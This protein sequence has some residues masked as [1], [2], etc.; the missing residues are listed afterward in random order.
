MD[1]FFKRPVGIY[2][3]KKKILATANNPYITVI[4]WIDSNDQWDSCCPIYLYLV[5]GGK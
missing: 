2:E 4:R 3:R 5:L 1:G